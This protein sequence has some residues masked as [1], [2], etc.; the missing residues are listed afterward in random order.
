MGG[1]YC[2]AAFIGRGRGWCVP[3][4]ALLDGSGRGRIFTHLRLG[5]RGIQ[6][7]HFV[8][9]IYKKVNRLNTQISQTCG[10]YKMFA[11]SHEY[12]KKLLTQKEKYTV[13]GVVINTSYMIGLK[14]HKI[15]S[16]MQLHIYR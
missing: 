13:K 3:D 4:L 15:P 16:H 2:V 1:T 5:V 9:N 10:I 6:I 8:T 7:Q 12:R 14:P 11:K